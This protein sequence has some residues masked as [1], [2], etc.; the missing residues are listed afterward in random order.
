MT[1]D[2]RERP[3]VSPTLHSMTTSDDTARAAENTT[4]AE[5]FDEVAPPAGAVRTFG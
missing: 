4:A 1:F 2:P 3:D 5:R